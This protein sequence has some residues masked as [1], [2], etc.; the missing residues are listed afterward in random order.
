MRVS[1]LCSDETGAAYVLDDK[2]LFRVDTTGKVTRLSES[3]PSLHALIVGKA[4]TLVGV[5]RED[6]ALVRFSKDGTPV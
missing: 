2:K 1:L 4:G 6:R 5:G 3:M